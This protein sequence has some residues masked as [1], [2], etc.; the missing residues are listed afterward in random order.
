MYFGNIVQTANTASAVIVCGYALWQGRGP[1]RLGGAALLADWLATPLLLKLG[2]PH[3]MQAAV[4]AADSAVAALLLSLAIFKNRFWPLWASAF[5]I[6]ELLMHLA[7]LLDHQ[8]GPRSYF[9]GMEISSYL[10]LVA[11]AVGTW[12]EGGDRRRET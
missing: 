1:E 12:L 9:I 6:L 2:D 10:I 7:R 4:F 8:V 5:Q 3:H 11:L